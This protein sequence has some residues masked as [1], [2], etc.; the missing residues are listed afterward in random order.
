[1]RRIAIASLLVAPLW[2][3][4]ATNL[5]TNGSFESGLAGWTVSGSVGDVY[6]A[7]VITYNSATAYPT[8]AFGEAVPVDNAV[9]LGPDAVGTQA[10]YFVSD[11]S[12]QVVSQTFTVAS[13]GSYTF[14]LDAYLPAN[15]FAN[16]VNASLVVTLGS[17]NVASASLASLAPT[18][19]LAGT[20]SN[21]NLAAGTYTVS[22][23]FTSNG[24][25]AKDIVID[26]IYLVS[27]VPEASTNAMLLAGLAGLGFVARRRKNPR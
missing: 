20:Y 10:L 15:G 11:F 3:T 13:S 18:T 6:P 1:M 9:N 14:G 8:G 17:L 26:K 19:W 22:L 2:A 23:A 7:A 27:S 16:P 21:L 5:I 25:P 24:K 4:A 12:T